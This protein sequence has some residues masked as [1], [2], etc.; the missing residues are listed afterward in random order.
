MVHK[1][2][3]SSL[4]YEPVHE[5]FF[6]GSVCHSLHGLQS[7]RVEDSA[8]ALTH[9]TGDF[10]PGACVRACA[11]VPVYLC[12]CACAFACVRLESAVVVVVVFFLW[13]S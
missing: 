2:W 11:C 1:K 8:Q 6:S 13:C 5:L 10:Q 4:F 12:F 7:A 9:D 3:F